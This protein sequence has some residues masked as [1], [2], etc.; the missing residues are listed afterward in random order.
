MKDFV[1]V[2]NDLPTRFPNNRATIEAYDQY[3]GEK[4]EKVC[5]KGIVNGVRN[6]YIDIVVFCFLINYVIVSFRTCLVEFTKRE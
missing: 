2:L 3:L 5:P 6:K 1:Q 4:L